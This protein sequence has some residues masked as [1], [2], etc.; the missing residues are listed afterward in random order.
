MEIIKLLIVFGIIILML[1][2]RKPLN[3]SMTAA[4]LAVILLYRLSGEAVLTALWEG[5]FGPTTLNT[6][7]VLYCITFLQRMMEKRR[8]LSSCQTA[9]SGLFNNRRIN[10]SVVP[11]L[12]GCLPAAST[13]VIC[14]PIVRESVGDHLS[15]EESADI[16]TFFRHISESFLPTYTGIFVAISLTEGR[17]SPALFVLGMLPL[18]ALLFVSGWLIYLRKLPR[19]TGLIPDRS[20]GHYVNMLIKSIWTIVL[21]IALILLLNMKVWAAVLV[22]IVLNFFVN[23]FTVQE[24]LPFFRSAFEGNLML[25]SIALMVFGKLVAASGVIEVLPTY[26][27]RLPLPEY[28]IYAMLFFF[29]TLVAGS[30]AIY[31]MCVPMALASVGSGSFLSLFLLIMSMSYAVMQISPTHICL[32]LCA[33]DYKIPLGTLIRRQLPLVGAFVPMAFGYFFLL[34]A[35]GL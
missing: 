10:V 11:F 18:V 5:I 19:D 35:F 31:V 14:G 29:G 21:A 15:K 28:L 4:G 30:Q 8:Q 7:A 12:L 33:E 26:F 23:H 34:R 22:V 16:T 9:M 17:V 24:I 20:R 2:L 1:I 6:L 3:L 25:N 27:A 32:T 13:V